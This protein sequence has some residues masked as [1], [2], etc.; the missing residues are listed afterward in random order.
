[1]NR[2]SNKN[3]KIRL[4]ELNA[5]DLFEFCNK[6]YIKTDKMLD[7]HYSIICVRLED[8]CYSEFYCIELV[9]PV[10]LI[11]NELKYVIDDRNK[12][13]NNLQPVMKVNENMYKLYETISVDDLKDKDKI[14]K[15]PF[16]VQDM[17][18]I[19]VYLNKP[20][21]NII[22]YDANCKE[23][24]QDRIINE[25]INKLGKENYIFVTTAYVSKQEYPESKYYNSNPFTMINGDING[26]IPVLFSKAINE[27][28]KML[29]E[30]GFTN[31]N[32]ICNLEYSKAYLYT[33]S[34]L[35]KK[36]LIGIQLV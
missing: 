6:L 1:M 12:S 19:A 30:I 16:I 35:G 34:E 22:N 2:D 9:Y 25:C 7:N 33:D 13:G 21:C 3:N 26:K 4:Y 15:M 23:R 10:E 8:G 17:S 36:V 31:I 18:G 32:N 27:Q 24:K 29:K 20:I 28:G 14:N 11:D 5:G